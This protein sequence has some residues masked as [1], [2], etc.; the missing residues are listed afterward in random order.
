MKISLGPILYYWP[1]RQVT[2]FYEA[3]AATPVDIVYL[4]ETVCAK[5]RELRTGDWLE[6]GAN[7]AAAGKQVVLSTL[8]LIEARSELRSLEKLCN[9]SPCLI[10]ANDMA[11]VQLLAQRQLPFVAGPSINVYNTNT[12]ALLHKFGLRRWVM[13]VELSGTTL[14]A[15]LN[16]ARQR[17]IAD[18]IETEVFSY[19][20][21]PLAYSARC[22]TARAGNLPKDNCQLRCIE[23]PDG[24]AMNTRDGGTLFTLNGIQTQSGSI[25]NLLNQW[26]DMERIGVDILRISPQSQGTPAVIAEFAQVLAGAAAPP[27][28]NDQCNGYWFGQP[29]MERLTG[30]QTTG[31]IEAFAQ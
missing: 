9:D 17:Q 15:I 8:A 24:L 12:L 10:E 29:G 20:K 6:I 27:P 25:C 18:D 13:P 1:Q 21:L 28:R 22:F 23:A 2:A 11:A 5:R 19:G 4:G 3:I 16:E 26:Q 31:D 7:L 14:E 30:G